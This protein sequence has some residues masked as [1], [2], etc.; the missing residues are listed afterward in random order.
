LPILRRQ[1]F[2][3]GARPVSGHPAQ[4]KPPLEPQL[5]PEERLLPPEELPRAAKVESCFLVFW[6]WQVGQGGFW[7]ASEKRTIFSNG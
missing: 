6:L 1:S 3:A 5:P 7:L 4:E 2:L